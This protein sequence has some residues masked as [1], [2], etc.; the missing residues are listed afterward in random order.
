MSHDSVNLTHAA[1]ATRLALLI[2]QDAAYISTHFPSEGDDK[3]LP[4]SNATPCGVTH[5][6]G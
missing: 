2:L 6:S 1:E 4:P 3:K 5:V